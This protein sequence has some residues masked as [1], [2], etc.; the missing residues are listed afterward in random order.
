MHTKQWVLQRLLDEQAITIGTHDEVSMPLNGG[1][2]D[3]DRIVID[4]ASRFK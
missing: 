1:I 2:K 3:G 4:H